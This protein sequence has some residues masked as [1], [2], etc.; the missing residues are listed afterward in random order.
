MVY[1]EQWDVYGEEHI[2]ENT[3]CSMG[4]KKHNIQLYF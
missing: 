4:I 2:I 1:K 3:Q